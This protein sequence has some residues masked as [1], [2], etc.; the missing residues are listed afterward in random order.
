MAEPGDLTLKD[1]E[2]LRR[3][4]RT[5]FIRWELGRSEEIFGRNLRVRGLTILG[6]MFS[7]ESHRLS[8]QWFRARLYAERLPQQVNPPEGMVLFPI[9][10]LAEHRYVIALAPVG[11]E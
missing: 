10:D 5:L 2:R 11:Q 6:S 9:Q 4:E 1:L 8:R 7:A 3:E